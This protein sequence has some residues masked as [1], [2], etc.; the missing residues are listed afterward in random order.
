[1]R[2]RRRFTAE[3]KAKVALEA[4][5]GDKTIQEI[6]ARSQ[7]HPNQ[8]SAWKRQAVDGLGA[9]FSNGAEAARR[10]REAE[11]KDLHAKI[12]QLTVERDLYERDGIKVR[13]GAPEVL[14]AEGTKPGAGFVA[15][16][17]GF[18]G[19]GAE[20]RGRSSRCGRA[21]GASTYIR[22][23]HDGLPRSCVHGRARTRGAAHT[24]CR[25][26]DRANRSHAHAPPRASGSGRE[27]GRR[28]RF[29][30]GHAAAAMTSFGAAV[31]VP[32]MAPSGTNP[33]ST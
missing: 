8:I 5:R 18:R 27:L 33:V 10:D 23:L 16:C 9:V 30:D 24:F 7:V 2:T 15:E 20:T 17:H 4:L 3:F 28:I 1:M 11:I 26:G 31:T 32:T 21:L 25:H 29:E 6:A 19:S 22:Q 13:F 14:V 12:G